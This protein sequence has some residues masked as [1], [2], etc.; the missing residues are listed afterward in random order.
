[1]ILFLISYSYRGLICL[2]FSNDFLFLDQ[3]MFYR[4]EEKNK[5]VGFLIVVA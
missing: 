1:M 2:K 3:M 4:E 5:L